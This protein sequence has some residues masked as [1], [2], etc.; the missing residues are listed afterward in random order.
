MLGAF[1]DFAQLA[2]FCRAVR[3]GKKKTMPG[4]RPWFFHGSGRAVFFS[5][6][7]VTPAGDMVRTGSIDVMSFVSSL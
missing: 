6:T 1:F 4:E 2:A 7:A 3:V 5:M